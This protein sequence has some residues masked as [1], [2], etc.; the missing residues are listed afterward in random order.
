[1]SRSVTVRAPAS[2]ANLGPGFDVLAAALD[3]WVE[4]EVAESA[5]FAVDTR[6]RVARDRRNIAVRAFERL[7][8][9]S[10]FRFA[11]RSNVPLSG[12]LGS[13]AAAVV[14][15]LMAARALGDRADADLLTEASAFEGHPDNAAAAL[16]GGFVVCTGP[17]SA[18][19]LDPP[20]GLGAVIVVPHKAVRTKEARAALP[21][22]VPLADAAF[23]VGQASAL[24]LGLVRGDLDLIARG[25]GDRLHQPHRAHLFPRSA[26]LLERATEL[27]AL[28]ATVSGAGPT[29]LLWCRTERVEDVLHAARVEVDGWAEVLRAPF[30]PDGARLR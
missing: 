28:G 9:P 10:H 5:R 20:D 2:S 7:A 21:A 13:S 1:M 18:E 11:I 30:A 26:A 6:L 14:C 27:G 22:Q 12:G 29:V 24:V 25:L 17:A 3:L 23:N 4:I 15:G 8:D 19:R 16:L